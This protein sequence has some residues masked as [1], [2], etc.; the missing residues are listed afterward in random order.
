MKKLTIALAVLLLL[1]AGLWYA[2]QYTAGI[3]EREL[4]AMLAPKFEEA[5]AAYGGLAVNPA[6]GTVTLYDIVTDKAGPTV[7]EVSFTSEFEDLI[8]AA[9]GRPDY[10]H[11]LKMH[12]EGLDLSV[13]GDDVSITTADLDVDGIIDVR[14]ML[15]HPQAWLL[16][17]LAQDDLHIS[18]RGDD[19][20]LRSEELARDLGLDS[21]LIRMEDIALTMHRDGEAL[22]ADLRMDSP[23]LGRAHIALDGDDNELRHFEIELEGLDLRPE[24]DMRL[25]IGQSTITASGRMPFD[26]LEDADLDDIFEAGTAVQWSVRLRDFMLEDSG[27]LEEG[28]PV[29]RLEFKTLDH[30][31]NY[32]VRELTTTLDFEGNLGNCDAAMD[33]KI[34]ALDPPDVDVKTME[35]KLDNLMPQVYMLLTVMPVPLTP[36]GDDGFTYSYS[37]PLDALFPNGF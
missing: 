36:A 22:D 29:D 35:V 20:N 24:G 1:A 10:L 30:D 31:F 9:Q 21:R 37:G 16:E 26:E 2:N 25:Q 17:F 12:L 14:T 15:D 34:R 7:K 13:E 8:A 32:T 11:G 4:D 5:G 18:I 27:L 33:L 3:A 6:A 19:W 28:L 23:E